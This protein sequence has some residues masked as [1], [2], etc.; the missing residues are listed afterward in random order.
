MNNPLVS[1]IMSCYNETE[2]DLQDSIE[3]ILNQTYRN[4]EFLIV[5]DNPDNI[6]LKKVLNK[7]SLNDIRIKIIN[8]SL[9]IGLSESLNRAL[10]ESSGL[11]VARMDADDISYKDRLLKQVTYLETH[12]DCDLVASNRDDIDENSNIIKKSSSIIVPDNII[13]VIFKYGSI[14]THP[15][16][17]VKSSIIKK[18]KG[19][20]AF[21]SAQD[22][23]LWLRMV[24]LN[25]KFHIIPEPLIK[26]RIR[27]NGITNSNF[28]KSY[29][30]FKYI[31]KLFFQ[32][33]K[34]SNKDSYSETA[35]NLMT[36]HNQKK[37]LIINNQFLLLNQLKKNIYN[38]IILTKIIYGIIT[39]F[40]CLNNIKNLLL[41]KILII[42]TKIKNSS[43]I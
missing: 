34:Y 30:E 43:K 12:P 5:N 39:H 42:L 40:D 38:P 26:Y 23:D 27:Q 2:Q 37:H 18:L 36:L 41:T 31:R 6:N 10:S 20:R 19:Y 35:F 17:M 3:S 15:S 24:S 32:R 11:Y 14:I 25:C 22:Y 8:N 7:Y 21:K 33:K 1:V 13:P 4:I 9:N 28:A 16:I 29:F